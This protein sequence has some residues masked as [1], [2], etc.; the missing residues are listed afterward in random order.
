MWMD[1]YPDGVSHTEMYL[2]ALASYQQCILVNRTVYLFYII[3]EGICVTLLNK[4]DSADHIYASHCKIQA[5][6]EV[7]RSN[8]S[9]DFMA[10]VAKF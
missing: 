4:S 5:N 9:P 1:F 3:P 2:T 10:N 6:Q 8:N 7:Y